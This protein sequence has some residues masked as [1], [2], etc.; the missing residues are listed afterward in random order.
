MI[1]SLHRIKENGI[2]SLEKPKELKMASN[3]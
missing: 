3:N 2:E 1:S